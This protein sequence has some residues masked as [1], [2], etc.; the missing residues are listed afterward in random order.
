MEIKPGQFARL[1][2][3]G[4]NNCKGEARFARVWNSSPHPTGGQG[5]QRT[6]EHLGAARR[7]LRRGVFQRR[8]AS[9][10]SADHHEWAQQRS[11][12]RG[13]VNVEHPAS[14]QIALFPAS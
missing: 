1:D 8:M 11:M 13:N 12:I 14:N 3:A 7:V 2:S 9:V 4:H 10:A 5:Q 6:V